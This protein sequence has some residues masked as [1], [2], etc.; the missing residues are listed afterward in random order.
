MG[1]PEELYYAMMTVSYYGRLAG[2][3][4]ILTK[5]MQELA[6][7]TIEQWRESEAS[8]VTFAKEYLASN[9]E[10]KA[11]DH[12]MQTAEA[13]WRLQDLCEYIVLELS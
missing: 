13:L 3:Q 8:M 2:A 7:N 11:W 10:W 6:I 5:T 12:D 4:W 9:A 1:L